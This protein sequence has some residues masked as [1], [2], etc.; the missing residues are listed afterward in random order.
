MGWAL[1]RLLEVDEG[2][3][4]DP[5]VQAVAFRHA[6]SIGLLVSAS[7]RLRAFAG[8]NVG[9][10]S[11]IT[12]GLLRLELPADMTKNEKGRNILLHG[13]LAG[14]LRRYLGQ[15]RVVLL[16]GTTSEALWISRDGGPLTY[17]GF[18]AGLRLVM[19]REFGL[20]LRPH[21]FRAIA[22]S[23]TAEMLPEQVGIVREI[24]EHA[25]LAMAEL[26]YMRVSNVRA[27]RGYQSV[28]AG[29]R[30]GGATR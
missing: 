11:V 7:E 19:E 18:G 6:I 14:W 17:D 29:V 20:P 24:L 5:I 16:R 12:D 13:A 15:Y 9:Q 4:A 1:L 21:A 3:S 27:C 8:L 26:H 10:V 30:K 22:A 2:Q 23:G 28:A 25:T